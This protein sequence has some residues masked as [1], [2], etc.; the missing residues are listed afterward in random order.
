VKL[1]RRRRGYR[2]VL[3]ALAAAVTAA[4]LVP[5]QAAVAS[6]G[7]RA[8][9]AHNT[10]HKKKAAS[11]HAV[12]ARA[13]TTWWRPTAGLTWQWQL[14]GKLNRTVDAQVYDVDAVDTTAADVAAL[15]AAGRKV[16]CYVS[17]GSY[18]DW[19]PDAKSFP[20]KVLGDDLDGWAGE[21]WLDVRAWAA[22]AP[23]L[24]ARLQA[25]RGKG[26]DAVEPDNMD[27]YTND[28]GFPLTAADQL[29]Y[30]RRVADLAH[31]LGLAVGLKND[32]DQAATLQP[33]FDFAVNESCA[34]YRECGSLKSFTAAGKPVFHVEYAMDV[35]KF[36]PTTKALGF[37]S[38]RK[39]TDLGVWRQPCL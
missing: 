10:K 1:S 25:C 23:I 18:E 33:A 34:Q 9:S 4:A 8:K 16:I 39:R 11:A 15:H 5:P 27:G 20:A 14:S 26:F 12:P 13:T 36:C 31:S 37:S 3:T 28:T 7:S 2:A 32:V 38:L 21:R 19:R 35:A 30:N 17:A 6:G 22:L 29:T 24:T